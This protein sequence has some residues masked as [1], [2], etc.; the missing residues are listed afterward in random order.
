[1]G[2][3]FCVP[4]KSCSINSQEWSAGSSWALQGILNH[5]CIALNCQWIQNSKLPFFECE[6]GGDKSLGLRGV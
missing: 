1:M 5:D 3:C 6:M 2:L 4:Y